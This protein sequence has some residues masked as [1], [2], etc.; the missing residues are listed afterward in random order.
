MPAMTGIDGLK[1][2][3][4]L[5]AEI[6]EKIDEVEKK[7]SHAQYLW[8]GLGKVGGQREDHAAEFL[9]SV[10]REVNDLAKFLARVDSQMVEVIADPFGDKRDAA[11]RANA[12]KSELVV[13]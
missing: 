13:L 12:A 10:R 2:M 5:I 1:A 11:E 4:N 7:A 8:I 6:R 9:R 3:P